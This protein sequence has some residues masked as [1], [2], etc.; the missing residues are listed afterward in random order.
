MLDLE[1]A[2][3]LERRGSVLHF[4]DLLPHAD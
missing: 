1:E 2:G 3:R 4:L